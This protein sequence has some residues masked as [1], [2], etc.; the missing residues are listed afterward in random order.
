M[1]SNYSPRIIGGTV[2]TSLLSFA[3]VCGGCD[4]TNFALSG[5]KSHIGPEVGEHAV[6]A[7][8]DAYSGD[9]EQ[10]PEEECNSEP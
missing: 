8:S 7:T 2:V 10:A 5:G 4:A 3:L 9:L 6:D 1:A